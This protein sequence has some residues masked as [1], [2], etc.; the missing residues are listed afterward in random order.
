[1]KPV[2]IFLADGFEE[3]EAVTVI[4]VLRRADI[5]V[6]TV[7]VADRLMVEGAHGLKMKADATMKDIAMDQYPMI[8]LPGGATGVANMRANDALVEF[9][10][11]SKER[12]IAAICAAPTLL[13][14]LK[15]LR[16]CRA[17]CYP[18]MTNILYNSNINVETTPVVKDKNFITSRGPA[19]AMEFALAIVEDLKGN[20]RKVTEAEKMLVKVA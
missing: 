8:V 17:T 11:N 2:L 9:L 20:E 15:I 7:A 13:C 10:V 12:P 16:D 6:H 18:S 4:D 14:D 1:M 3:I 5:N 19:T